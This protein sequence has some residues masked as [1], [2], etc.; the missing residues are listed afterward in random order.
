MST[1]DT[2]MSDEDLHAYFDGELDSGRRAAVEAYLADHPDEAARFAVYREQQDAL[3]RAFDPVLDE[4]IPPGMLHRPR[5]AGR[6]WLSHAAAVLVG[7]LMGAIGSWLVVTGDPEQAGQS[8]EF[9]AR[10]VV[11]HAVYTPEVRHPVEVWAGERA[12]LAKWLSK[13]LGASVIV[14]TLEG[15]GFKLVGGRLL[16]GI[17]V[18]VAHF[19]YENE[20]GERVTI[21]MRTF[22]GEEAEIS[23][24]YRLDRDIGVFYWVN[25]GM[26]YAIAGEMEKENLLEVAKLAYREIDPM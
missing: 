12:H 13:R 10:A 9:A 17:Q 8:H 23:F 21:Y 14:P 20:A 1:R 2:S 19:M 7:I 5:Y 18:P 25:K 4:S 11:A 6:A 3:H 16:P 22:G 26:G 15:S 24:H